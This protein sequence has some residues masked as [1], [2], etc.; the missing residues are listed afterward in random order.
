[1][2]LIILTL[3]FL[4]RCL[5]LAGQFIEESP[6]GYEMMRVYYG[7]GSYY[8]DQQQRQA[9]QE[10][11]NSKEDLHEYE[12][13]VRSHTDNIGSHAYNLYLSQ[14][15][16]ESVLHALEEIHIP[17]EEVRVEDFGEEHPT[18]DNTTLEGRLSNRRVD[19]I[20]VPLSS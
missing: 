11:L 15:R 8:L 14:M 20:L 13:L 4:S 3:F 1:M 7:G 16:S 19:V 10:W 2:R 9:L 5:P 18:F 17:R 6:E 12:I